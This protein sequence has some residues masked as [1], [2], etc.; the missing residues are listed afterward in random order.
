MALEM[1]LARFAAMR[2]A[3]PAIKILTDAIDAAAAK[4]V[5]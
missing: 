3:A 5:G 2:D 1:A 4:E